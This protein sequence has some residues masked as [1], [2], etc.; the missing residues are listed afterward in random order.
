[1]LKDLIRIAEDARQKSCNGF[2]YAGEAGGARGVLK[3]AKQYQDAANK[4]GEGSP[5]SSQIPRHLLALHAIE[6][7][8]NAFWLAKGV[9]LPTIRG[10]RHD[11]GERVR[12]ASEAGLVLRKRTVTHLGMLSAS[13]EYHIVRYAPSLRPHCSR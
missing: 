3:L 4:L 8:L 7:Y 10:L 1:M 12:I 11:L 9:D 2:A 5:K 13:N 6:L